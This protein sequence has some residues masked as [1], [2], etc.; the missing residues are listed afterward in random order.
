L[1]DSKLLYFILCVHNHQPIGNFDY[2]MEDGYKKA[3]LPFLEALSEYPSIK[4]SLHAS[5]PLLDWLMENHKEYIDLL[6]SMVERGQVELMGGGYYE[7]LL[8]IIPDN[9][10]RG[11]IRMMSD[12]LQ[13]LF[14]RLPRGIWLTERVWE[15]QL[16]GYLVEAG[17]EYVVV[18]DYHLVKAGLKRE[19]LTGYYITEDQGHILKVFP[20]SER[21]RYLIPFKPVESFLEYLKGILNSQLIVYAD[22]GEKFGIWPGTHQWVYKDGWLK[23]FF[24]TL[25]KNLDWIRPVTFSEYMDNYEPIGRVYLPTTSYMEMGEWALPAEA[26]RE[27]TNLVNDIKTWPDGE[28]IRRFLQGGCW[29]N[30]LSKYPEANWMHKRMLFV[31]KGLAASSKQLTAHGPQITAY[32]L[33]YRAQCNDAYWHGVFGGLYLPHLRVAIYENL[34][35]AENLLEGERSKVKGKSNITPSTTPVVKEADLDA[36]TKNELLIRTPYFNLFLSPHRGGTLFELDYRPKAYNLL[37]VLSRYE[38]GYHSKVKGQRSKVK[39]QRAKSIH[40]IAITKEEGL[41]EA[42]IY[43]NYQRVSLLD[44]FFSPGVTLESLMRGDFKEEGDF[45]KVEYTYNLKPD[46]LNLIRQGL[47]FGQP[48]RVEKGII[49]SPT[50]PIIDIHYTIENMGSVPVFAVFASEWNLL[51]GFGRKDY[52]HGIVEGFYLQEDWAG[53]GFRMAFTPSAHLYTYPVETVSISEAGFEKNFQGLCIMPSWE[54]GL[55]GNGSVEFSLRVE[56]FD[57]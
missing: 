35:K 40:E 16:P 42:L 34:I 56:V 9:D 33:L 36:D 7:P 30:F 51:L 47:A 22:D 24:N 19:D 14:G 57:L 28:R 32:R 39:G 1:L 54:I 52:D 11:Q 44:R 46:T 20:G 31:S 2:I 27:Y 5:G 4:L 45:L 53:I 49:P 55:P 38:E 26:S 13:E 6:R 48:V 17:V 21:L 18:D 23:T 8:A 50:K 29:R 10:R 37:N 12:K 25:N 3:Y 43:D 41:E 15:P